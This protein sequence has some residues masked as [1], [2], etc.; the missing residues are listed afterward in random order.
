M[1]HESLIERR[2]HQLQLTPQQQEAITVGADL[3]AE[4][5]KHIL[6]QRQQVQSRP[7]WCTAAGAPAPA[8]ASAAAGTAGGGAAAAAGGAAAGSQLVDGDGDT[9]MQQQQ[10]PAYSGG[11]NLQ[12]DGRCLSCQPDSAS[13]PGTASPSRGASPGSNTN[14]NAQQQQQQQSRLYT[15]HDRQLEMDAAQAHA[16][17]LQQLLEEEAQLRIITWG[18]LIGCLSW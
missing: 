14:P 7:A 16:N 17:R 18:W 3:Y 12:A 10:Q 4:R 5:M 6:L 1:Q 15:L 8:A 9:N 11:S 2:M 13:R